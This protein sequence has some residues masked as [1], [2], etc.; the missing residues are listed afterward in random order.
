MALCQAFVQEVMSTL[1]N[2]AKKW[3]MKVE[4]KI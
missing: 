1:L 2:L 4:I 3:R